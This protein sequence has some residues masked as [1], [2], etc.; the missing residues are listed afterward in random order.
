[1]QHRHA[2]VNLR[3]TRLEH[4]NAPL[5]LLTKRMTI[6]QY[7]NN[8]SDLVSVFFQHTAKLDL[9]YAMISGFLN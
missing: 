8:L 4:S 5:I 6:V 7:C 9:G 3:Q 2:I 1:M